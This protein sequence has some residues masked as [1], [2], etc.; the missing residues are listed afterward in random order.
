[1]EFAPGEWPKTAR[2]LRS[3]AVRLTP[4]QEHLFDAPKYLAVV[5]NRF[6]M[7]PQALV[8]WHWAKAGTIEHAHRVMKDELG[9]GVLPSGRF[10]ASAA[11]FR[12][13]VLALNLLTVLRRKALPAHLRDARPK[14]LRFDVLTRPGRLSHH[15]RQ[16]TVRVG[17]GDERGAVL[18]EARQRLLA[19]YTSSKGAPDPQPAPESGVMAPEPALRLPAGPWSP[20]SHVRTCAGGPR[21]RWRLPLARP[22]RQGGRHRLEA[23]LVSLAAALRAGA[24]LLRG[25]VPTGRAQRG[26]PDGG[27]ARRP[28]HAHPRVEPRLRHLA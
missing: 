5:S 21:R 18:F 11:W 20:D 26:A 10:R 8:R 19:A 15:Q 14:R 27:R 13:N 24:R 22:R 28:P 4:T 6:E 25:P 1:M 9:A 3:V 23:E 7:K 17:A 16:L 2:P 12:V